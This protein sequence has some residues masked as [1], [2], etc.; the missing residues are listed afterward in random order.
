MVL[1]I[2]VNRCDFL[3]FQ[4]IKFQKFIQGAFVQSTH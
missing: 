4:S 2:Y 1:L 3:R